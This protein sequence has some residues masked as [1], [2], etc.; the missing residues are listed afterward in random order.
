M[1]MLFMEFYKCRRRKI[2][3]ICAG[4]L[5]IQMVW[6]G[7]TMF[8]DMD[9]CQLAEGWQAMLYQ[10]ALVDAVT[11]PIT[12]SAIISRNCEMEHKGVT[13]KLLE[14]MATAGCLYRAKLC[15]YALVVA[16]MLLLRTVLFT[17]IGLMAGFPAPV[18][19]G[20]LLL[21]YLISWAVSMLIGVLQLGLSLR[22]ANQAV[23]L[24]CGIL[25]SFAGLMSLLFPVWIQR[26][27]PWGYYGLLA[28]SGMSWDRA[29]RLSEFFWR[30]PSL[31]DCGLLVVWFMI[32]LCVGRTLFVRKEV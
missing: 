29:T 8:R 31:P 26:C 16:A 3:L 10:L 15:W 11:L 30:Q 24:V 32:F 21:F 13:L 28:L 27:A 5:G 4:L 2:W 14:T 6:L 1:N 19:V 17:G 7:G 18:P 20:R 23:A 22:F 9:A 25:G 12:V